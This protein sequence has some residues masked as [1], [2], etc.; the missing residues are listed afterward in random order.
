ML[1]GESSSSINAD[2]IVPLLERA[3]AAMV[4]IH[5]RNAQERYR[6]PADWVAIEAAAAASGV[7]VVGNGDLYTLFEIERR[8]Q[9]T[10]CSALMIGRGALMKPWVFDELRQ[11]LNPRMLT[12]SRLALAKT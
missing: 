1:P 6:R 2:V 8:K 9:N 7:P 4:T 12:L 11:V 5:G 3:G 10:S